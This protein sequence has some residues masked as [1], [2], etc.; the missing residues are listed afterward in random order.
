MKGKY[1]REIKTFKRKKPHK[2]VFIGLTFLTT[3][4]ISILAF[5]KRRKK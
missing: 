4:F 2:K 5:F 1:M 3:F